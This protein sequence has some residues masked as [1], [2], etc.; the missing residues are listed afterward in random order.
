MRCDCCDKLLDEVEATAKFAEKDGSK[1]TRFVN[2]CRTCQGF[3][4]LDVRV[5]NRPDL[6]RE[7]VSEDYFDYEGFD[8][9]LE[10]YDQE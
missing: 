4:P 3:L 10:D 9:D 1:P 2:M 5:V 8:D 6:E 7:E